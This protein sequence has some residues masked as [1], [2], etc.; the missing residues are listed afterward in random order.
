ML[1]WKI[2]KGGQSRL[3]EILQSMGKK[4]RFKRANLFG[5]D[6]LAPEVGLEPTTKR[7]PNPLELPSILL[8]GFLRDKHHRRCF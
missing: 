4:I 3:E 5:V 1:D 7:P 8:L 6:Y 2:R